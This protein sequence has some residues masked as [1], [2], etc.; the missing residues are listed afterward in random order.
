LYL[1]GKAGDTIEASIKI[2][3]SQNNLFSTLNIEQ[4][5]DSALMATVMAPEKKEDPWLVALKVTSEK[6]E[7]IFETL[8]LKTDNPR[9]P[10]I[11]IKVSANF[12]KGI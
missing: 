11:K 8:I 4:K 3:P 7:H 12:T 1:D 6:V 9:E 2:T 10:D 5:P